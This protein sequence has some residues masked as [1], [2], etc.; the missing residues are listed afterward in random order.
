MTRAMV[1]L[2]ATDPATVYLS[3][4]A[5]T[6]GAAGQADVEA[7]LYERR[8]LVRM[9]AMRRT[10]FAVPA[11]SV[12]VV[13][14]STS[15]RIAAQQRD[16]L[17][18]LLT[19]AGVAE[20]PDAWLADVERSV[21]ATLAELGGT[22]TAAQL[23][24]AEPRLK[25]AVLVA[26]GKSYQASQAITSRVL[27]VLAAQGRIVRGRPAGTWLSQQ[28]QWTLAENWLPPV[29]SAVRPADPASAMASLARLW[30]TAFGPAR[31][32]DLKW[33]TGWGMTET[34]RA[35]AAL[36]AAE[37]DLDGAAAMILPGDLAPCQDPGQWAALLPA[38]DPTVMGWRD[39]SWFAGP[40]A[41]ALF[42]GYGNAGPTI[43]LDGRIVGGWAQRADGEIAV[44]LFEDVGS[45]AVSLIDA[46]AE[47]LRTWLGDQRVTPRFRTPTERQLSA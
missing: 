29:P 26:A 41:P 19:G 45:E 37:V 24:A 36:G 11:E 20:R 35:V 4:R 13:Q 14:A 23:S 28:Y 15:D 9:L 32:D 44:R 31:L 22:A 2:H 43:W 17:L 34:R 21:L 38:L 6:G 27:L 30:L 10:V 8:D 46:E 16:R 47:S 7:S 18:R 39:R 33:W 12:T 5:R 40:H 3:V 42:D 25:T 1:A